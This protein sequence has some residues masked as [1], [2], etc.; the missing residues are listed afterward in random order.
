MQDPA[1]TKGDVWR[2]WLK[3]FTANIILEYPA[4]FL[5]IYVYY[6]YQPLQ[7]A[8]LPLWFFAIHAIAPMLSASVVRQLE[9]ELIGFKKLAIPLIVVCTYGMANGGFGWPVW[10]TLSID[11]SY[12]HTYPAAFLECVLI[13]TTIWII[14]LSFP[15]FPASNQGRHVK[16]KMK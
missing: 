16:S 9:K 2:L 15:E 3:S 11:Q 1:T 13:A 14:T 10:V 4:T 5:K 8:G 12:Y 6:G 7:V